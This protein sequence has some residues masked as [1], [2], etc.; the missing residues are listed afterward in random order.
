MLIVDVEGEVSAAS[1]VKDSKVYI[2]IAKFVLAYNTI[3]DNPNIFLKEI[4]EQPID[5]ENESLTWEQFVKIIN[6]CDLG[7]N[8]VPTENQLAM[9]YSYAIQIGSISKEK[10]AFATVSD[11]AEAQKKYYNFIDDTTEKIEAQYNKQHQIAEN[12]SAEAID[13]QKNIDKKRLKAWGILCAMGFGVFL[14]GLGLAGLFFDIGIVKFFGFGNRYVGAGIFMVVGFCLFFFLDRIYVKSKYDYLQYQKDSEKIISRSERTSRDEL[15]MRDKLDKF[16]EDLKIAKYE[17]NDKDKSYDVKNCIEKLRQKNKY[18]QM[19]AENGGK[20]SQGLFD[21]MFKTGID[22]LP[23]K[24]G[25][26][27]F[28]NILA[29]KLFGGLTPEEAENLRSIQNGD[30]IGMGAGINKGQ[31]DQIGKNAGKRGPKDDRRGRYVPR[32]GNSFDEKDEMDVSQQEAIRL[33]QEQALRD[34]EIAKQ[35]QEAFLAESNRDAFVHSAGFKDF[36]GDQPRNDE[37]S[38]TKTESTAKQS[39]VENESYMNDEE[40]L[41]VIEE[42]PMRKEENFDLGDEAEELLKNIQINRDQIKEQ[43]SLTQDESRLPEENKMKEVMNSETVK[44]KEDVKNMTP[45]QKKKLEE[46]LQQQ[47]MQ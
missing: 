39:E 27:S 17:L 47:E 16:R 33:A 14:C 9:Y 38:F 3:V 13:V 1:M 34:A 30:F 36:N 28:A 8:P 5:S 18:Y 32:K 45:E 20:A 2:E 43:E 42:N 24:D 15:I 11:V 44:N 19:L 31:F 21:E 10:K 12:R 41:K 6:T 7:F 23:M 25:R 29:D 26:K 40:T 37:T 4:G 22:D 46:Y 35:Q